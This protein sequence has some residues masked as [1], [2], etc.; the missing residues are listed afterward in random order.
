VLRSLWDKLRGK[1]PEHERTPEKSPE[2]TRRESFDSAI[3]QQTPE[4]KEHEEQREQ[5]E[6]DRPD[7]PDYTT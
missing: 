2:P 3:P 4:E 7:G 1:Q 6:R 5:S